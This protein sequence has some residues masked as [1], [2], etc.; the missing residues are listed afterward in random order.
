[1][2]YGTSYSYGFPT[3]NSIINKPFFGILRFTC[4]S[5]A[6]ECIVHNSGYGYCIVFYIYIIIAY[7]R[8]IGFQGTALF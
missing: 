1:M 2:L 7:K 4:R 8:V 3:I 6:N 5:D